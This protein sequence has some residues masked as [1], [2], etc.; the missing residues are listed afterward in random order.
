MFANGDLGSGLN[1]DARL[2]LFSDHLGQPAH[3]ACVEGVVFI[4][5]GKV[6]LIDRDQRSRNQI[7]PQPLRV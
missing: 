7:K 5:L 2:A 1:R 3:A 6:A 4:A